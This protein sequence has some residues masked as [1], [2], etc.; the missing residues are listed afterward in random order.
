MVVVVVVVGPWALRP[1]GGVGQPLLASL[2]GID[3]CC[4]ALLCSAEETPSRRE[5]ELGSPG[6]PASFPA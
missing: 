3:F 1:A 6:S 4:S 5:R 2:L